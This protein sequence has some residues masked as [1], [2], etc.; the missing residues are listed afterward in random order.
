MSLKPSLNNSFLNLTFKRKNIE[1]LAPV[2][3]FESLIA[4]IRGKANA[5]YFGIGKLN[6]RSKS[7]LN[8]TIEDLKHIVSI[9]RKNKIKTYIT[10]NTVMFDEDLKEMQAVIDAA[11][12]HGIDA[13]IAS[14]QA[15]LDYAKKKKMEIHLSTQ[16]NISNFESLKFYSSYADVIVLARELSLKQI[17]NISAQIKKNKLYGPSGKLIRLELFSHGALCM[18][19]SGK[20]YLSLHEY[21]HSANRGECLQICR[22]GYAVTDNETGAELNIDNEYIMSPKD[23]CSI[24]F[25]D[26]IIDSGVSILKIEGR[27]RSAEYVKTVC[28]CYNEALTALEKGSYNQKNIDGWMKRL[29][30]VFNRGFWDGYYL[31]KRLGEWSEVYGSKATKRKTYLGKGTNYFSKLGVAE[32]FMETGTLKTGDEIL[33]TGPTT[34]VIEMIVQEIHVDNKPVKKAEKGQ[35]FSIK[36]GNQIRRSDKLF[37]LDTTE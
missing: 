9:C 35:F 5:V 1:L 28:E 22:R 10:L 2:G 27:A 33:I 24:G 17:K 19:V 34:G 11:K 26:K 13:I 12:K 36:T 7:T 16:I 31:G 15:A 32:F 25:L 23:L 6:M 14:D 3:S 29:S 30:T 20:C 8:F 21:N 37:R 4:A 18:S